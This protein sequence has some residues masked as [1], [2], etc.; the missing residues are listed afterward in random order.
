VI[1]I[2]HLVQIIASIPA[3]LFSTERFF[4]LV[5]GLSFVLGSIICINIQPELNFKHI[6]ALGFMNIWALRLAFFLFFRIIKEK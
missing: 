2:M 3:I 1:G 4:D 5:G 6:F